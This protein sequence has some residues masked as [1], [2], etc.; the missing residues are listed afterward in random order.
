MQL[1]LYCAMLLLGFL[2]V[3]LFAETL[4]G[5]HHQ[6]QTSDLNGVLDVFQVY[7]PVPTVATG[8]ADCTHGIALMDHVFANSYGKP[9]VG[10]R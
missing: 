5:Y 2:P 4:G 7:Q 1:A 9:F 8:T 10:K 3:V 6:S